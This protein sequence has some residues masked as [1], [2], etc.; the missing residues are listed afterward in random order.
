MGIGII[1]G[2]FNPTHLG[3]LR[4]LEEASNRCEKVYVIVNNDK[5]QIIKKGKIIMNEI[6]RAVLVSR[7][8]DYVHDVIISIDEDNTV[9]KTLTY[10]AE[11]LKGNELIFFNGGDRKCEEDIPEA[12][13]CKIYGIKMSFG[14]GGYEKINSSSNINKLRGKE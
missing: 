12:F 9:C 5:Q 11:L 1:S 3:H 10:L 6:E 8:K 14:C 4:M 13:I 2:F 7:Y